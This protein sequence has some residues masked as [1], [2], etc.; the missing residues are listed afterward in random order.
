MSGGYGSKYQD[1]SKFEIALLNNL[2]VMT[3]D[4]ALAL[5]PSLRTLPERIAKRKNVLEIDDDTEALIQDLL[6]D[7]TRFQQS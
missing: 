4:E 2:N 5:V 3:S 1:F 7:L 6:N